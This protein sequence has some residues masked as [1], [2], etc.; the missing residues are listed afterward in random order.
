MSEFHLDGTE[1][2]VTTWYFVVR[3]ILMSSTGELFVNVDSNDNAG[4][5]SI[6]VVISMF[7]CWTL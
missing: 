1:Q 5:L 6:Y 2:K 4:R 7:T 3:N